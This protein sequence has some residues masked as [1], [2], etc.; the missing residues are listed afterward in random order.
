[1]EKIW[2][3]QQPI[4]PVKKTDLAPATKIQNQQNQTQFRDVFQKTLNHVQQ[5]IK[6]SAHASKRIHERGITI[7]D[8]DMSRLEE[9]VT[10][11]ANK[12]SRD[13]LILMNDVAYVVSVKNKTVVTAVDDQTKKDNVFTN[14][15]SAIFL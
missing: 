11:A 10:K 15:D 6:F 4:Q 3:H 1:M 13:A 2:F 5:P 8:D 7:S 9:A 12:G 14:I